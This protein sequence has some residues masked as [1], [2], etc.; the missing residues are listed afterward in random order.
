[1]GK[2]LAGKLLLAGA[3]FACP[4]HIPVYGALLGGGA[5]GS[6]FAER[7]GTVLSLMTALFLVSLWW[8]LNLPRSNPDPPS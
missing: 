2:P 1:M 3:F 7:T 6:Y 4:C 8:G 5:L